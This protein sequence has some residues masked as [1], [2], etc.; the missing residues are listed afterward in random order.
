MKRILDLGPA[1]VLTGGSAFTLILNLKG[2]SLALEGFG[3]VQM[4]EG[5]SKKIV[6]FIA[7]KI[8]TSTPYTYFLF[9]NLSIIANSD[10]VGLREE[11]DVDLGEIWT[12]LVGLTV[13][14]A[15]RKRSIGQQRHFSTTAVMQR[16]EACWIGGSRFRRLGCGSLGTRYKSRRT[17]HRFRRRRIRGRHVTETYS[18]AGDWSVFFLLFFVIFLFVNFWTKTINQLTND[19]QEWRGAF[20]KPIRTL[21][22]PTL[23]MFKQG[24]LEHKNISIGGFLVQNLKLGSNFIK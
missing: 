20:F 7:R 4:M 10:I 24:N 3:N 17:G 9:D 5:C 11:V 14:V 12:L 8:L 18:P 2:G 16:G 19:S 23:N 6:F 22:R 1:P 15:A 13:G 21:I